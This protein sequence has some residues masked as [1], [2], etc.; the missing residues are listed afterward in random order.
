MGGPHLVGIYDSLG[1][2]VRRVKKMGRFVLIVL[3]SF[4]R[5]HE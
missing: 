2:K 5:G 1:N 3:D 4:S